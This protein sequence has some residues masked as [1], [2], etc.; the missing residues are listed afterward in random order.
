MAIEIAKAQLEETVARDLLT[1]DEALIFADDVRVYQPPG[2]SSGKAEHACILVIYNGKVFLVYGESKL[3]IYS[4]FD[5]LSEVKA[6]VMSPS[7]PLSAA[8]HLKNDRQLQR[9]HV[10]FQS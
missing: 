9:S 8:F 10:I 3:T 7:N 5:L 4:P 6:L 1:C 2:P